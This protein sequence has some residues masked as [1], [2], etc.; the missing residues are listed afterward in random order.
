LHGCAPCAIFIRD[1]LP[2]LRDL[3]IKVVEG[4]A[5]MYP[6]FTIKLDKKTVTLSGRITAEGLRYRIQELL[7]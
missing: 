3:N 4:G 5:K 6:S 7:K 1:E 2:M